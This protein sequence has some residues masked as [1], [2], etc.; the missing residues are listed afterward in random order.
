M[1]TTATDRKHH[2][3]VIG[4]GIVGVCCGLHLQRD[5]HQVTLIDPRAPGTATSYGNAGVIAT[6]AN[7]PWSHPGLWKKLPWMLL[8]PMSPTRLPWRN[9]HRSL[10]WVARFLA[11]GRRSRVYE[12]SD[13]IA[14]LS[15]QAGAAHKALIRDHGVEQELVT[16]SGFL[17]VFEDR[18]GLDDTALER[19]LA[20]RHG[21]RYEVLSGDEIRQMEPGL[22]RNFETGLFYPDRDLVRQPVA[23]TEAYVD[24]FLSLG[25]EL[26][27]ETVRRFETGPEGPTRL[28]TDLG[29][30]SVDRLVIAAGA[31]SRELSRQLGSDVPLETERGYHLNLAWGGDV[32]LNRPVIV[33]DK[34]YVM[35][36]MRDGIRITSGDEL[37]GLTLPPDFR[38]IRR[39]VEDARHTLAGL[40]TEVTREWMGFRP[41]IPDSKPVVGRSPVFQRVFYA[42][43][44]G[45]Y[46]LTLS[47]VTGRL[48]SDLVAG[49]DVDI[50]LAP[51]RIDRF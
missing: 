19:E 21:V 9:L 46:G 48:I 2:V 11:A 20:E 17:T 31:W 13:E 3:T 27:R 18:S 36:P 12:L 42:F 29:F 37:G 32:T 24:A 51:F 1:K 47:A 10:P 26:R 44:H 35:V 25:G 33:A 34:H 7:M 6:G 22:T 39:L 50:P 38:R 23:L 5:G 43:G 15:A 4:A 16:P 49:R 45:H 14:P 40:D 41:S 30:Y 8:S 28:V